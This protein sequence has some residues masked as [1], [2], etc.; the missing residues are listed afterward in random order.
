[1]EGR[2]LVL[3][4]DTAEWSGGVRMGVDGTG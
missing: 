3:C 1:L 2:G 4:S